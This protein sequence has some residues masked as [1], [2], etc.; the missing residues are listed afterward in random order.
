M[1]SRL[2]NF[3]ARELVRSRDGA[4][5]TE[6][7]TTLRLEI[8]AREFENRIR[9]NDQTT[10]LTDFQVRLLKALEKKT[11][12]SVS[13]PTSAGK[14]FTLELE[15]LRQLRSSAQFCVVYLV[16]TRALVRQV[17]FDL[18]QI[19][20]DG[21]LRDVQVLSVPSVPEPTSRNRR[22]IYVLTQERFATLLISEPST[23][24]PR[25]RI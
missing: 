18:I 3:P 23:R 14:S 20:R 17:T 25:S 11:Y 1:L 2:G 21:E 5:G 13:A 12:V 10:Y 19:L 6:Q 8:L 16:P 22:L 24:I 7:A 15:I 4:N 9:T